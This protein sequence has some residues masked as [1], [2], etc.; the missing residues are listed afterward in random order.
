M[1]WPDI[2]CDSRRKK[3]VVNSYR[4]GWKKEKYKPRGNYEKPECRAWGHMPRWH[5]KRITLLTKRIK[6]LEKY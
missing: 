6:R 2:V 1:S 3:I 4:I 5:I